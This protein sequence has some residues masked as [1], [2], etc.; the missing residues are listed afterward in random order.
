[1]PLQPDIVLS[2]LD[3]QLCIHIPAALPEALWEAC[4]PSN[5]CELEAQSILMCNCMQRHKSLL[6]ASIIEA[7]GQLKKGAEVMMLSAELMRNW[8]TSLE[9]ANKAATKCRQ[10]KKKWIQKQGTLT[11]REEENILAQKEAN[12]QMKYE[13]RQGREQSGLSHRALA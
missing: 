9:R 2:K 13:Q 6:Q 10:C 8:I 4:I 11:K 1:V 12:Q 5:V 7:I 3:V